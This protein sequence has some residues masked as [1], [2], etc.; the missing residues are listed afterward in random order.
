MIIKIKLNNDTLIAVNSLLKKV[1]ELPPSVDKREN[2]Y[3]SIGYGLADKF[4]KKVKLIIRKASLFDQAKRTEMSLKFH[5]SW[6][7]QEILTELKPTLENDYQKTLTQK[8][9]NILD[10]KTC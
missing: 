5:E 9:I 1:Y 6:A 3:K 7:L 2:I 8:L 4:E 10:Q